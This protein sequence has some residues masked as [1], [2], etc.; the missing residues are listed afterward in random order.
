M[1]KL[2]LILIVVLLFGFQSNAILTQPLIIGLVAVPVLVQAVVVFVL[3]YGA[4]YILRLPSSV[5]GPAALI[6]TSNFF[7]LA[8]A[9]AVSVFGVN[10]TAA[11]ATVVGVLV[12][13]PIMLLLVNLINRTR[14]HLDARVDSCRS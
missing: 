10:S 8:V 7:E 6:G 3:A 1:T 11:I 4:A 14:D 9:I 5:A 2:G 12:E 13:V